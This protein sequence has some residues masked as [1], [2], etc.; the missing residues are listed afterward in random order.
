MFLIITHIIHIY[1]HLIYNMPQFPLSTTDFP[2]HQVMQ[3]T[4][5][6]NRCKDWIIYIHINGDYSDG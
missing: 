6:T 4:N 5:D 1:L 2:A 3:I